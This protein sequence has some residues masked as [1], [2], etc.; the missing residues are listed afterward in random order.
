M[1]KPP[2]PKTLRSPISIRELL[3]LGG[4]VVA[5]LCWYMEVERSRQMAHELE[6]LRHMNAAMVELGDK[7][8]QHPEDK[9][10]R[11]AFT[12]FG[13]PGPTL[14]WTM[15]VNV[16]NNGVVSDGNPSSP[17]PPAAEAKLPAEVEATVKTPADAT[18]P[19]EK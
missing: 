11:M 14:R 1:P 13:G 2:P 18:P 6:S 9:S 5:I 19:A 16:V 15:D 7:L 10:A 12:E 8:R 4:L 17:A 3:L